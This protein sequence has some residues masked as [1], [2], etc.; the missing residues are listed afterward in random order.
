M[1]RRTLIVVIAVLAVT[2][3]TA[4][5]A[6]LITGKDIR[7]NSVT[8]KDIKNRSLGLGDLKAGARDALRGA[9]GATGASGA[10]GDTGAPGAPGA[11]GAKGEPGAKGDKGAK[12]DRGPSNAFSAAVESIHT[13]DGPGDSREILGG[14]LPAGNFVVTGKF[15]VEN[16]GPDHQR[17]DCKLVTIAGEDDI[18]VPA[19]Q[20]DVALSKLAP[21]NEQVV[22]LTAALA[23]EEAGTGYAMTCE[24]SGDAYVLKFRDRSLIAIQVATIDAA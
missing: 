19:D 5:A 6:K 11:P 21:N 1:L 24:P 12:G 15:V 4:T 7:N 9:T 22:T 18:P 8:G 16:V 20:V 3:G 2:S 23:I 17:P 14:Q 10:K 13:I